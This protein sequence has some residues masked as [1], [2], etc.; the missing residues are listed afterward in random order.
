MAFDYNSIIAQKGVFLTALLC[1]GF[2]S[3]NVKGLS[4][5]EVYQNVC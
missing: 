5:N 3:T 1:A 4:Q 2:Q